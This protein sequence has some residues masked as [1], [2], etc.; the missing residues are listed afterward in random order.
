MHPASREVLG[1]ATARL[2][3]EIKNSLTGIAGAL[4]VLHDRLGPSREMDDVLERVSAEVKRIEDS[5]KELSTF[6]APMSP[7]LMR[8]DLK[9]VIEKT[10]ESAPLSTTTKIARRYHE[11]MPPIAV[12]RRLLGQALHRILLNA[13]EAMPDGGTLTVSTMWDHDRALISIRDTGKGVPV[14]EL[15]RIFEPFFSRKMRGLGLGLA[16]S[17]TLVDAHGGSLSAVSPAEG[18]TEFVIVLPRQS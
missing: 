5:V 2:A 7:V 17:R 12:D 14:E 1:Q 10:L 15:E 4:E 13:E 8:T 11:A 16:I 9:D 3:H 6:A 18:G